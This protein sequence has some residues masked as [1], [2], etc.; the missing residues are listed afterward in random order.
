MI[1]QGEESQKVSSHPQHHPEAVPA[2][3]QSAEPIVP[4]H[5]PREASQR[6]CWPTTRYRWGRS[7]GHV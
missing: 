5:V 3:H 7:E 1:F 2:P 6:A 4:S